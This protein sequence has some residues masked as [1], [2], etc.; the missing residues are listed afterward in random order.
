MNKMIK[1]LGLGK[2][3]LVNQSELMHR[4]GEHK[5]KCEVSV[6]KATLISF[7]GVRIRLIRFS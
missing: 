6:I 5:S 2:L 1:V 3:Y 4:D 7:L